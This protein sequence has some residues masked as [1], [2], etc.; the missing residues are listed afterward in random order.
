[1]AAA[2]HGQ[3][4]VAA[5]RLGLQQEA[6]RALSTSLGILGAVPLQTVSMEST[7]KVAPRL[8]RAARMLSRAVRALRGSVCMAG[9]ASMQL[10]STVYAHLDGV[11]LDVGSSSL[12]LVLVSLVAFFVFD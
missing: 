4:L 10:P 1:M 12:S 9:R 7:L 8:T 5:H 6:R 3:S 2:S 11:V